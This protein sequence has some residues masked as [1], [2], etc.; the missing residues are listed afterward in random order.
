[1]WYLLAYYVSHPFW[2]PLAGMALT[3]IVATIFHL[4]AAYQSKQMYYQMLLVLKAIK[5]DKAKIK[6]VIKKGKLVKLIPVYHV[7]YKDD[8]N[9]E[10]NETYTVEKG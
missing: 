9:I 4:F 7:T 2:G 10:F 6:P 5:D 1:M 8:L 3:L